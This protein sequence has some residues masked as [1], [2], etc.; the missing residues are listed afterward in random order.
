M[1]TLREIALQMAGGQR[2]YVSHGDAVAIAAKHFSAF[3]A[4]SNQTWLDV[5][6][7]NG[8]VR[9]DP[10]PTASPDDPACR[11][12][13]CTLGSAGDERDWDDHHDDA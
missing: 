1:R 11:L 9:V 12:I 6:Q 10:D 7:R 4:P 8:L 2:D 3:P 13:V 5:I